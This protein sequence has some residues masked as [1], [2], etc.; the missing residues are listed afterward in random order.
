MKTINIA[1]KTKNVLFEIT[2][3]VLIAIFA[4]TTV[5]LSAPDLCLRQQSAV[6]RRIT[7]APRFTEQNAA[8]FFKDWN[9]LPPVVKSSVLE[10]LNSLDENITLQ[11]LFSYRAKIVSAAP[12]APQVPSLQNTFD[13]PPII[14]ISDV[15]KDR[16]EIERISRDKD[17]IKKLLEN[18]VV[19]I[20][21]GGPGNRLI[22]SLPDEIREEVEKRGLLSKPTFPNRPVSGNSALIATLETLTK[23]EE[24]TGIVLPVVIVRSDESKGP[25]DREIAM[26]SD[27]IRLKNPLFLD[28]NIYPAFNEDGTIMVE[29]GRLHLCPGGTFE[30]VKILGKKVSIQSQTTSIKEWAKKNNKK[31][32]LV[33]Y[34]DDPVL[35]DEEFIYRALA[36][37]EMPTGRTKE[38][39]AHDIIVM[40]ISKKNPKALAGGVIAMTNGKPVLVEMADRKKTGL[41]EAEERLFSEKGRC[42]PFN[43]G[44]MLLTDE[45][46]EKALDVQL[47]P[48]IADRT[49]PKNKK[50]YKKAEEFLTD[51]VE[52]VGGMPGMSVAV[53]NIDEQRYGA[54]KDWMMVLETMYRI[55]EE[56]KR[57]LHTE[58]GVEIEEGAIV[59]LGRQFS[60]KSRIGKGVKIK[61]GAEVYLNGEVDIPDN[62]GFDEPQ[63]SKEAREE[64][65]RDIDDPHYKVPDPNSAGSAGYYLGY[66]DYT[67]YGEPYGIIHFFENFIR[68]NVK[69]NKISRIFGLKKDVKP[70]KSIQETAVPYVKLPIETKERVYSA[71]IEAGTEALEKEDYIEA[72]EYYYKALALGEDL[73]Y[74]ENLKEPYLI[75]DETII[76]A[77]KAYLKDLGVKVSPDAKVKIGRQFTPTI[78]KNVRIVG[79][80]DINLNGEI[81]IGDNVVLSGKIDKP[82]GGIIQY[83]AVTIGQE[84]LIMGVKGVSKSVIEFKE[85]ELKA[86]G[87]VVMLEKG[88]TTIEQFVDPEATKYDCMIYTPYRGY[89]SKGFTYKPRPGKTL[90]QIVEENRNKG[91]K[92]L[93]FAS[94]GFNSNWMMPNQFVIQDGE[95]VR[96]PNGVRGIWQKTYEPLNGPYTVFTLDTG[97]MMTVAIANNQLESKETT[98]AVS[99]VP[100]LRG[101]KEVEIQLRKGPEE[102]PRG[103]EWIFATNPEEIEK[104]GAALSCIGTRKDGSIV[105]LNMIGNINI[106]GLISAMLDLDV[107]DAGLLGGSADV[108]QYIAGD[109]EPYII[110]SERDKPAE[111]R[112][113]VPVRNLGAAILIYSGKRLL[114]YNHENMLSMS[115]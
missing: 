54:T 5:G 24:E 40:T 94:N 95:L 44:V 17:V 65:I 107:V 111:R 31:N 19:V 7:I 27:T 56:S 87:R 22:G 49:F 41:D 32:F 23:I 105:I 26:H 28:G 93:I 29:N 36:T 10:Q 51:I 63:E 100:I 55:N 30:C 66:G 2:S 69:R 70:G 113:G 72:L 110:A 84:E 33:L 9:K 1:P 90:P 108:Q 4:A 98:E 58:F 35:N 96:K 42:F 52:I 77:S 18:T 39:K 50:K 104:K 114:D 16:A 20:A 97:M 37:R 79:S 59:E 81:I 102:P 73:Y 83:P 12:K 91:N 78:G 13:E 8:Q 76:K 34:G 99:V 82:G 89:V 25:I 3:L 101:G 115:I 75:S 62:A 47:P 71:Y 60:D 38:G 21:A 85:G 74:A 106:K 15:S 86:R 14:D 67:E 109:E 61:K 46:L 11:T 64:L 45:A 53:A 48:H 68:G 88:A 103:D 57:R 6:E 92:V 80:A 112:E 43:T